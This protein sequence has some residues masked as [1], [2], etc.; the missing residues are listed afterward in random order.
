MMRLENRLKH[1]LK[2]WLD[3]HEPLTVA[4]LAGGFACKLL[5][6]FSLS[7]VISCKHMPPND[8]RQTSGQTAKDTVLEAGYIRPEI[9]QMMSDPQQRA[10][11]YVN[12]YWDGYSLADTAF[13]RSD[14]TEQLFADFIGALQY[15]APEESGAA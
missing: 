4:T 13:I 10:L 5:C 7:L 2:H 15:V 3:E 12:H 1:R 8:N 9:P 6:L 14:D 11:Y